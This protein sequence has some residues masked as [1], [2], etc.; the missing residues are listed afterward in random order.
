TSEEGRRLP[1]QQKEVE[2]EAVAFIVCEAFGFDTSDQS[3]GYVG[4][5]SGGNKRL[6]RE[7][8]ERIMR[9][10]RRIIEE[11]ERESEAEAE[12]TKRMAESA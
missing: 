2:A 3:V 4:A 9:T 12:R 8:M 10:A 6:F 11:I 5:W 7:S 1:R